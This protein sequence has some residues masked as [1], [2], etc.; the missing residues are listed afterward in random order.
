MKAFQLLTT[1]YVLSLKSLWPF[2][3]F[4]LNRFAFVQC[5]IAVFLDH[6]VM[7]KYVFTRA[8]LDEAIAFGA[9]KPLNGTL[10]LHD[11]LLSCLAKKQ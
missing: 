6:G 4:K 5:P 10:F 2:H 1:A 7:Y 3:A 11:D 8:A 9:I